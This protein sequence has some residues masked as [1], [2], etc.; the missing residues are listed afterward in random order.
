MSLST[1]SKWF[2]NTC[3][4]GD[5]TTSL[6]S[7]FQCSFCKEV[8]PNIQ[9]KLTLAQLKAISPLPV[10]CHPWEDTNPALAGSAFQRMG[11]SNRVS[12]QP[13]FPQTKHSP[14]SFSEG[15]F[16]VSWLQELR[17]EERKTP[18]KLLNSTEKKKKRA[19]GG[20]VMSLY[21][22]LQQQEEM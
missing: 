8:F 17:K 20:G 9:P 18:S 3:R 1:T 13:P 6:G 14:S 21:Y 22:P 11:D 4:D 19:G 7:L 5:S 12:P 16:I 10:T 15:H 2:L